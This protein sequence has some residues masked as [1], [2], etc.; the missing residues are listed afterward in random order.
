[1]AHGRAPL[2]ITPG[3]ELLALDLLGWN[4]RPEV[5][6]PLAVVATAYVVGW[7]RLRA[8]AP[9]AATGSRLAWAALGALAVGLALVSAVDRLG[10]LLLWVHMLQH[11]L[12]ITVA[13]PAWLLADPFPVLLWALPGRVR[14]AAGA[15]FRPGR[16][17]R[18]VATGVTW[19]PVAW[20]VHVVALW[21]WHLPLAYDAA[22]GDRLT[23]DLEH[24]VFFASA[25]VFWWPVTGPA[26]RLRSPTPGAAQVVY[27]VLAGF[28]SA[29]LGLLLALSPR[30]LY[31]SYAAAP[32]VSALDPLADQVAGGIV[33]WGGVGAIDMLAVL[34]VVGRALGGNP[35]SR[36]PA[37]SRA[38]DRAGSRP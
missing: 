17:L 16:P 5:L 35:A 34:L 3:G 27:L 33:M 9:G 31:P 21:A 8:R 30:V 36:P 37:A 1:M 20:L 29:L 4:P 11:A 26:P 32:R 13:A 15:L 6:L 14:S 12:L 25:V 28:Q 18:R 10:H 7:C 24:L 2:P 22:L 19:L 23:H 38:A